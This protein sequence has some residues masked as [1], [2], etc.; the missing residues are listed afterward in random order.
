MSKSARKARRAAAAQEAAEAAAAAA[1]QGEA[2][3]VELTVVEETTVV[4]EVALVEETP[5][6]E[7]TVA[8]EAATDD[9]VAEE[10]VPAEGE[11]VPVD[12]E[13]TPAEGAPSEDAAVVVELPP[14]ELRAQALRVVEAMI[15]A[16]SEALSVKEI[17]KRLPKG[18]DVAGIVDE[19]ETHYAARGVNL[20]RVA[21]KLAF[22]TASDVAEK[23]KIERVVARK[24][25][26]AATETLAIVAY[27]T[28][29]GRP[30]TRA[31]IEE[32]RGVALSKGTLEILM[33]AE[34]VQPKGHRETPGRPVT[35]ATTDKF[36]EHFGLDSIKALPGLKELRDLGLLDTRPAVS[37]YSEDGGLAEP[38]TM[39]EAAE[40][41]EGPIDEREI[42]RSTAEIV[43]LH[44]GSDSETVEADAETDSEETAVEED[45]DAVD[46][47]VEDDDDDESE[48]EDDDE[49]DDDFDDE[50]PSEASDEGTVDEDS[51]RKPE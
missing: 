20:V 46:D 38:P 3:I 10:A 31:E 30:V 24:L 34:F 32:I 25:S 14:E 17:A 33:E 43:E 1:A 12:G 50:E 11:A 8:D 42:E 22:R 2:Q 39:G 23:L 27:Q 40:E 7:V 36:L 19:I 28:A 18:V 49:D 9:T 51:E 35:Y 41:E 26:K 13:A 29:E 4:E 47:D 45:S 48:F 21:G 6:A 5:A 44:A 37:A 16:S 15:F